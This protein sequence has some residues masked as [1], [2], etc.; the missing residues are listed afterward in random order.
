MYQVERTEIGTHVWDF[1]SWGL[2]GF[3]S[4]VTLGMYVA[5]YKG[6]WL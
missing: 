1:L 5:I 6:A 4:G 3:I 2:V